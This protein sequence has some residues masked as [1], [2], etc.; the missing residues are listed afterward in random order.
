MKKCE[1]CSMPMQEKQDFG[2]RDINCKYCKYCA[3]DGKLRTREEI[4]EGWINA[5]VRMENIHREDAAKRVDEMMPKMPAWK[6]K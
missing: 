2:A 4:R 6:N 1:S 3:P 5:I